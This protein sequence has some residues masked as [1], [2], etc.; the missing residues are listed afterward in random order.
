MGGSVKCDFGYPKFLDGL[1]GKTPN[2]A[3][4]LSLAKARL[5]CQVVKAK[6]D[7]SKGKPNRGMT[8]HTITFRQDTLV[9]QASAAES[10]PR[11]DVPEFLSVVLLGS[12]DGDVGTKNGREKIKKG[13]LKG[14]LSLR[15]EVVNSLAH[16]LK[17]FNVNYIDATVKEITDEEASRILDEIPVL[18]D[19]DARTLKIDKHAGSDIAQARDSDHPTNFQD[20][21]LDGAFLHK[22]QLGPEG[23]ANPIATVLKQALDALGSMGSASVPV[24]PVTPAV[25][26]AAAEQPMALGRDAEPMNEFV[27]N[28]TIFAWPTLCSLPF[29]RHKTPSP[30][31]STRPEGRY[32]SQVRS[33]VTGL[34]R[35]L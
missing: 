35:K 6:Q 27:E 1:D 16:G 32:Q 14:V 21:T 23:V 19:T 15:P 2:Q 17:Q 24:K 12:A 13:M 11:R 18:F 20:A 4:L 26:A 28:L 30:N 7:F 3:E 25:A 10:F 29:A 34:L 31:K 33:I 5:F 8:G 9:K 22:A